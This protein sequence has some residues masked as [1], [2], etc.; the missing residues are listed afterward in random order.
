MRA[1]K[2]SEPLGEVN[3]LEMIDNRFDLRGATLSTVKEQRTIGTKEHS[4]TQTTGSL[5]L[6]NADIESI[7]FSHAD[8]SYGLFQECTVTDCLFNETIAKE[9]DIYA[10]DFESCV[11]GKTNFAYS[12]MNK[13]VAGNA[14]SFRNCKFLKTNLKETIFSFPIIDNCIFEDCELEGADFDGSRMRNVTFAGDV[15]SPFIRG[16][17]WTAETSLFWI[18]NKINPR[19]YPNLMEN[20]DFSRANIKD[21]LFLDEI[22]LTNCKF[23]ATG[24]FIMVNNVTKLFPKLRDIVV[25]EW[26]DE[27]KKYALSLIDNLYYSPK[28]QG[29]TLDV[30]ST[31]HSEHLGKEFQ[32][33][34]DQLI[35]EHNVD[36]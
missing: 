5:K 19:D 25:K 29:M 16:Y 28:K 9:M 11:F 1:L 26:Q 13:N 35:R 20:I 34:L 18:F 2:R 32:E 12:F 22:D 36:L 27:D 14:G 17:S 3:G 31:I 4:L 33:R 8:I 30:I 23:P 21:I 10:S 6:K 15:D 7:D 24:D